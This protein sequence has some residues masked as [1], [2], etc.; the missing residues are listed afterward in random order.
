L[1]YAVAFRDRDHTN[2]DSYLGCARLMKRICA[3]MRA[4]RGSWSRRPYHNDEM[5]DR[6]T[7]PKEP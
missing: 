5:I 2:V 1:Y 6:Q 3:G 4:T 7:V